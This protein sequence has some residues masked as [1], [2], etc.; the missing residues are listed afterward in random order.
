M[1]KRQRPFS[2]KEAHKVVLELGLEEGVDNEAFVQEAAEEG[3]K[4][5]GLRTPANPKLF[6]KS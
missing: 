2:P 4:K 3:H 5:G 1:E 6:W